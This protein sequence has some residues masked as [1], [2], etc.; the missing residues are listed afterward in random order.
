MPGTKF[1]KWIPIV[2]GI[3]LATATIVGSHYKAKDSARTVVEQ[4]VDKAVKDNDA[5]DNEKFY[6]KSDGVENRKDI[7]NLKDD[8]VEIK[9]TLKS[10][11]DNIVLQGKILVR[12]DATLEALKNGN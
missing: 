4:N 1:P 9:S 8:L 10:V 3:I 2:I 12:M 7:Q 6:S 5:L 11:N